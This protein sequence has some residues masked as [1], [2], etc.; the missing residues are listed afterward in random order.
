MMTDATI[1][2]SIR[3]YQ[4]TED[5]GR[6][7]SKWSR[8]RPEERGARIEGLERVSAAPFDTACR[9]TQD[10]AIDF[11]GALGFEAGIL[12]PRIKYHASLV[13]RRATG[14]RRGLV[15]YAARAAAS[16]SVRLGR[17]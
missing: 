11:D 12:D 17:W 10:A 13:T 14:A 2:R 6:A 9:P 5:W 3:L 7:T 16:R 15:S 8:A 4:G 1:D